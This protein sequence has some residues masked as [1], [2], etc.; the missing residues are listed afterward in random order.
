M[1]LEIGLEG[2]DLK[3]ACF[4]HHLQH[5]HQILLTKLSALIAKNHIQKA[6]LKGTLKEC[7]NDKSF[8]F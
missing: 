8:S 3:Q 6:I 2:P 4:Q 1:F 7:I 5:Q